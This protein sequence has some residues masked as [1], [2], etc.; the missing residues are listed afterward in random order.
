MFKNDYKLLRGYKSPIQESI[1]I[2]SGLH[3]IEQPRFFIPIITD[4]HR[5]REISSRLFE[6]QVISVSSINNVLSDP[7]KTIILYQAVCPTTLQ[8]YN[9]LTRQDLPMDRYLR[10]IGIIINLNNF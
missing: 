7:N 3:W 9:H 5:G 10:L 4:S 1:M 8:V 2:S 6:C